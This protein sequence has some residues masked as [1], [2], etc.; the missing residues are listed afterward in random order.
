MKIY[1][2]EEQIDNL[3]VTIGY[4]KKK[5]DANEHLKYN[6]KKWDD[7]YKRYHKTFIRVKSHTVW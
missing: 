6:V 3:W 4:F 7:F 1:T 2:V 5:K